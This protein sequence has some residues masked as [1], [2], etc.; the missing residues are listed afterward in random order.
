MRLSLLVLI[1]FLVF[2]FAPG[3]AQQVRDPL[4]R[5]LSP[6]QAEKYEKLINQQGSKQASGLVLIDL[7]RYYLYGKDAKPAQLRN[8]QHYLNV[9]RDKKYGQH[10][11]EEKLKLDL[12]IASA[13]TRLEKSRENVAKLEEIIVEA[14]RHAFYDLASCAWYEIGFANIDTNR[15]RNYEKAFSYSNKSKNKWLRTSIGYFLAVAVYNHYEFKRTV[16]I[17]LS[18]EQDFTSIRKNEFAMYYALLSQGYSWA[19]DHTKALEYGLMAITQSREINDTVFVTNAYEAVG[20][21]YGQLG[22]YEDALIYLYK[23]QERHIADNYLYGVNYTAEKIAETYSRQGNYK[24]GVE[25]LDYYLKKYPPANLIAKFRIVRLYLDL[26]TR[27]GDFE[28]ADF[29]RQEMMKEELKPQHNTA[30]QNTTNLKLGDFYFRFRNYPQAK[31]HYEAY[32]KQIPGATVVYRRLAI[33]DSANGNLAGALANYKLYHARYDSLNN[34]DRKLSVEQMRYDFGIKE[35]DYAIAL[36][37]AELKLRKKDLVTLNQHNTL[38]SQD[39]ILKAA[40][41]QT[42]RLSQEKNR[43]EL[44]LKDQNINFL[45]KHAAEQQK[46]LSLQMM[47]RNAS[48]AVALLA[49]AVI[50]LLVRQ[51]RSKQRSERL[52]ASQNT[53]LERLVKDKSWLVKEMHHRVKNNLQIVISLLNTQYAYLDSEVAMAAIQESQ[54]RMHSISLIHQRLYQSENLTN[55]DMKEYIN[56]LVMYLADSFNTGNRIRIIQDTKNIGLD[57]SQAVP[58]GL[59]LNE[60]VTNSIKYAFP[61]QG[62][63]EIN[64][65]LDEI[66]NATISLMIA[67]N[68]KGLPA[69]FDIR[70]SKSLGM[71][72]IKGLSRQLEGDFKLTNHQGLAIHIIIKKAE[73]VWSRRN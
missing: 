63:G 15:I 14:D 22:K 18:L 26:Y 33:I 11:P 9:A 5:P 55:I 69:D 32:V 10:H 1:G 52:L 36:K 37:D 72:L 40:Q 2:T 8:A 68:G 49:L 34:T 71:T 50:Y 62:N 51:Y 47:I 25:I 17:L 60:A 4:F 56:E 46:T 44:K 73:D 35:K 66:D 45:S 48:I 20:K 39:S 3:R 70:K 41:L 65:L 29:Y 53:E 54:H 28:K 27:L 67:D 43:A 38:L 13:A 61:A 6:G 23:A 16:Q 58:L 59:I 64:I 31:K 42:A 7:A 21:S 19:G 57:V 12:L 30:N 24:K